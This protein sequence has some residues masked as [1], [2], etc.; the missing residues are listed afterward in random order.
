MI[1]TRA[2]PK[3]KPHTHS[4]KEC[5]SMVKPNR[6]PDKTVKLGNTTIHFFAP[7]PMTNEDLQ[8]RLDKVQEAS[9]ECWNSLT[10]EQQLELNKK[11]E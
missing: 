7:P 10:R 9:W 11:Y 8:K 1:T 4:S 3:D 5:D 6:K 2:V